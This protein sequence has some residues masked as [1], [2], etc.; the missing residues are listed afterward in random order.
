MIFMLCVLLTEA[1]AVC[2]GQLSNMSSSLVL[3]LGVSLTSS[4]SCKMEST[5]C[6]VMVSVH[7]LRGRSSAYRSELPPRV[8]LEG[9]L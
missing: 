7:A 4:F 8:R 1:A 3:P 9:P 2:N 6:K 5:I